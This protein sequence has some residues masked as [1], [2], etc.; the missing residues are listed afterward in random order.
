MGPLISAKSLTCATSW[1]CAAW[2]CDAPDPGRRTLV[3]VS[4]SSGD[5]VASVIYVARSS[6]RPC[7]TARA[8]Y[9]VIARLG[10]NGQNLADAGV[11]ADGHSGPLVSLDGH[12]LG[13]PD[14]VGARGIWRLRV[15][16]VVAR[17]EG[18]DEATIT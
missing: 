4:E 5:D 9:R 12:G 17:H 18:Y 6:R 7:T 1:G 3:P 8:D 10:S 14:R 11:V 16:V 15:E 2:R 13:L